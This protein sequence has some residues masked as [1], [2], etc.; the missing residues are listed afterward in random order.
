MKSGKSFATGRDA[1]CRFPTPGRGRGLGGR[2][3]WY[4][5]QRAGPGKRFA[6]AIDRTLERIAVNPFGF[7]LVHGEIRRAVVREFPFG[8]YFRVHENEIV[9]IAVMHGRRHPGR[10]QSRR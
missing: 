2:T 6:T 1:P 3:R 7:P 10:W 4:E 8:I 5:E 9:V